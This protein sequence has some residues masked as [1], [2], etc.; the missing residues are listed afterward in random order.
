MRLSGTRKATVASPC[1]GAAG[2]VR[3]RH[4]GAQAG[5]TIGPSAAACGSVPS[6]TPR[7]CA[8]G[9]SGAPA[10]GC[11]GSRS[12]SSSPVTVPKP[13]ILSQAQRM[14]EQTGAAESDPL[15]T[16]SASRRGSGPRSRVAPA[17]GGPQ[18]WSL[19]PCAL[20]PGPWA[21]A[22]QSGCCPCCA[23]AVPGGSSAGAQPWDPTAQQGREPSSEQRL[24][25]HV[26]ARQKM[27]LCAS[28]FVMEHV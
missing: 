5:D 22:P 20:C 17:G 11:R 12:C 4:R 16:A 1:R 2:A 23:R 8:R 28:G 6:Q 9:C 25:H 27:L 19:Q 10:W 24:Q 18:R 3:R 21:A 14:L 7:C 26:N 15:V 13:Q